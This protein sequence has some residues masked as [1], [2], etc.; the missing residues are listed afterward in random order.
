MIYHIIPAVVA[1]ALILI[2]HVIKHI[3]ITSYNKRA[4]F[5]VDFNNTFFDFANEVFAT[6]RMNGE[7]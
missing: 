3:R 5:T 4:E 6:G 2:G 7:K 1:A